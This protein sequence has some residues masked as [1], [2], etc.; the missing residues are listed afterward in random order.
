M[1]PGAKIGCLF[2]NQQ[3]L[4]L[5]ISLRF[6]VFRKPNYLRICLTRYLA[7]DL[8]PQRKSFG[9]ELCASKAQKIRKTV[10]EASNKRQK[11]IP[12]FT[13]N[14]FHEQHLLCNTLHAKTTI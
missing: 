13:K 12:K 10:P 7:R 9:F 5:N 4:L 2:I 8:F 14:D 3:S 1:S 6:Y 11:C